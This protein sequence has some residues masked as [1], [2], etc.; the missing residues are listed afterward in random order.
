MRIKERAGNYAFGKRKTISWTT[1]KSAPEGFEAPYVV[2]MIELNE[3]PIF[4]AQVVS[5]EHEM[6]PNAEV[7]AVFRKLMETED[8]LLVY[9]TKF[10]ITNHVTD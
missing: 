1:I 10:E 4:T 9:G 3:G 6:R 7:K 5:P 8:S 2:G